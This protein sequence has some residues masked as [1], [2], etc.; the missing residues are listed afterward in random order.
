MTISKEQKD[1]SLFVTVEGRIDATTVPELD[2]ELK[3]AIDNISELI[4]DLAEVDYVSSAGLRMIVALQRKMDQ[5]G[6]LIIRNVRPEI[7]RILE[8]TGLYDMLNI[9]EG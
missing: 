5:K 1:Q 7:S 8:I 9:Q 6:S 4:L 3:S 2:K